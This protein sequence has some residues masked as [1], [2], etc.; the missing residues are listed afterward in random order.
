MSELSKALRRFFEDWTGRELLEQ[1]KLH[2]AI[3]AYDIIH[4]EESCLD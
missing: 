3:I 4:G 2:I 1:E